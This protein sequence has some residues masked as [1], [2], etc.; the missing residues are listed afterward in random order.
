VYVYAPPP[1]CRAGTTSGQLGKL[2]Q[3]PQI[4]H[5]NQTILHFADIQNI[6]YCDD[7]SAYVSFTYSYALLGLTFACWH[8]LKNSTID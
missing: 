1:E 2:F 4:Q 8:E 6:S 7:I 3:F 5:P